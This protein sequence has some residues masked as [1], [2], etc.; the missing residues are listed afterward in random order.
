SYVI[1]QQ[2]GFEIID[3]ITENE[4]IIKSIIEGTGNSVPNNYNYFTQIT[5]IIKGLREDG[6]R[7]NNLKDDLINSLEHQKYDVEKLSILIQVMQK[8][9]YLLESTKSC[10]YP[11]AM[12]LIISNIN[13]IEY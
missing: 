5:A 9:E 10:D 4:L 7:S 3:E 12:D 13:N 1:N 11:K 6:I 8:F 2:F